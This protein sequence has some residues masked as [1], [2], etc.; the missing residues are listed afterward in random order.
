MTGPMTRLLHR[1]LAATVAIASIV[2]QADDGFAA[3][4]LCY[5]GINLSGAEYGDRDG[6]FGVNYTYNSEETVGYFANKGMNIVRLPFRWER[7]QPV[8]GQP[9]DGAELQRLKDAVDLIQKH[10]MAVLLDPHNFGYYDKTQLTQAPATDL[11][12]GDFWARLAIEF[13]N[14]KG[15]LFGLMNEPH[16]IK[17]PDWLEAANAA[18]RS[19]RTVGARNLILVPGTNWTG[20][21]SWSTDVLG[22]GANGTVM[23]GV[24]DPL[25]FYAF[26][27]H[28]YLDADSSGTHAVCDGSDSAQKGLLDV[29]EWLRKNGKRGFLGEFGV[30]G[31]QPCLDGLKAVFGIMADHSDV[32]LGWSYWAAGE[33]WPADEPLNVQPRNGKDR[34][35]MK[36]ITA[37]AGKKAALAPSCAAVKPAG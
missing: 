28:Q 21:H 15:V 22:G 11:A 35:Q 17:A 14:R 19:I 13:A 5:R 26:E 37:A 16:D 31:T 30:P 20:A 34:P 4:Q 29:T 6:A 3:S 10:G 23:L 33:W 27:F 36:T 2:A 24:K 8:L 32:W 25:D 9:F 1:V 12:F 7:L 18:I